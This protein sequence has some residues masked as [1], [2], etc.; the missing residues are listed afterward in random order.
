MVTSYQR[1]HRQLLIYLSDLSNFGEQFI[2]LLLFGLCSECNISFSK[3]SGCKH[4]R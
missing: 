4:T 1:W 3:K 2:A